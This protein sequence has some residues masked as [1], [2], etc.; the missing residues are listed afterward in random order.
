MA[1]RDRT[2]PAGRVA[3]W[4]SRWHTRLVRALR[5]LLPVAALALLSTLFLLARTV[6]PDDAI[7][8]A[9]VD[10]SERARQQQLTAP[11]ITGVSAGG[12]AFRLQ[13]A[14]ARP[15]PEDARRLSA[16][17][18]RLTLRDGDAAGAVVTAGRGIADT[19]AR[20]VVLE[21]DVRVETTTGYE[22]RSDRLEGT[23]GRLRI[24]SPGP[25]AGSG[26]LGDLR[27]GTMLL[28]EDAAGRQTL[29]F[30]GGVDLVYRPPND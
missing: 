9:E 18:M 24:V 25:V 17:A 7:P 29:A 1:A 6:D 21:G 2:G 4:R 14:D 8:F 20:S 10:V 27:A 11:R 19:S 3:R 12:T 30:T 26:P 28:E 13:A 5:V 16:D 15:D 22:F 23:L